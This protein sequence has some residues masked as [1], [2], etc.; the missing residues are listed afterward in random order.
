VWEAPS[1]A[2]VV[3]I[4]RV[5][6]WQRTATRAFS[7]PEFERVSA[8]YTIHCCSDSGHDTMSRHYHASSQSI[9]NDRV[10]W[11]KALCWGIHA[12]WQRKR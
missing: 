2:V 11:Q 9:Y 10:L 12:A 3:L 4:V 5:V 6:D 7:A 1:G 8:A